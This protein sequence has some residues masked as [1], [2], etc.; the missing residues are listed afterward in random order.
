[1]SK[2]WLPLKYRVDEMSPAIL[3]KSGKSQGIWFGMES[4]HPEM[5]EVALYTVVLDSSIYITVTELLFL[6]HRS[7]M[8]I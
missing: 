6:C 8:L 5:A 2:N 4:G 7:M 3:E 1:M